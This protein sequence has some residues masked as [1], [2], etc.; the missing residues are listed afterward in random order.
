MEGEGGGAEAVHCYQ[1]VLVGRVM[2]G[3]RFNSVTVG[4]GVEWA[5]WVSRGRWG[6]LISKLTHPL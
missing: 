3:N 4:A 5:V 1:R 6:T 2:P